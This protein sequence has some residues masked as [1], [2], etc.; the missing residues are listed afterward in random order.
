MERSQRPDRAAWPQRCWEIH[1]VGARGQRSRPLR[2]R[3]IY[4]ELNPRRRTSRPLYRRTIGWM[5]QQIRPIPGLTVQEQVSYA[6]W[7]KGL[8]SDAA[9]KAAAKSL[10]WTGLENLANHKATELSG[11]QLRRVGLAQVLAHDAQVLLL[12]EPTA[13]L[14][15]SQRA[16]FRALLASL[17]PDKCVVV[18]THQIDDLS[19][20]FDRV[21]ILE[22]GTIQYAGSIDEF[23]D[24]AP[25][26]EI[27]AAEAA[28]ARIIS[29]D[30]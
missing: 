25:N 22:T 1:P 20:L 7:L 24:F 5:P 13:G 8:G 18:S 29:G 30:W 28:Y 21:V 15:P 14:D 9:W 11:G 6:A 12:D 26:A 27:H 3:V 10:T 2:G 4:D 17:P 23:M 19:E 16:R